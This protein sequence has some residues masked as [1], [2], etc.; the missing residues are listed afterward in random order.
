MF[1][2]N[3]SILYNGYDL[4][5]RVLKVQTAACVFCLGIKG[6]IIDLWEHLFY[7]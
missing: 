6:V 3:N 1:I 2:P 4:I 5:S 7:N